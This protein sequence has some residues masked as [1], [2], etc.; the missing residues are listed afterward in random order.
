MV[1]G[2]FAAVIVTS[3]KEKKRASKSG[4]QDGD[5]ENK[6]ESAVNIKSVTEEVV[7]Q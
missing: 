2:V 4:S 3:V 5:K 1:V 6:E 7:E